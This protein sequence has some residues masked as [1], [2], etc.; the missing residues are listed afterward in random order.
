MHTSFSV[1]S[2]EMKESAEEFRRLHDICKEMAALIETNQNYANMKQL[3]LAMKK[4]GFDFSSEYIEGRDF[5]FS[6]QYETAFFT[7]TL[8]NTAFEF[9]AT[10]AW[11]SKLLSGILSANYFCSA[12]NSTWADHLQEGKM[13]G[14]DA[15]FLR[16][17]CERSQVGST[18]L[19]PI[20]VCAR[21]VLGAMNYLHQWYGPRATQ[22]LK[23]SQGCT[24]DSLCHQARRCIYVSIVISVAFLD[25][26][27]ALVPFKLRRMHV[28][29][30]GWK[31]A[32]AVANT[33]M[34]Y[35]AWLDPIKAEKE[36]YSSAF[37]DAFDPSHVESRA[38][39]DNATPLIEKTHQVLHASK[40]QSDS[41]NNVR[42]GQA[43]QVAKALT[44]IGLQRNLN[45][46]DKAR[47]LAKEALAIREQAQI[48]K[49]VSS[50]PTAG[51]NLE[52]NDAQALA[53]EVEVVEKRAAE[54]KAQALDARAHLVGHLRRIKEQQ[55]HVEKRQQGPAK[56]EEWMKQSMRALEEASL[57]KEHARALLMAKHGI[58]HQ[59]IR[60][61]EGMLDDLL[62]VEP[63]T[64]HWNLNRVAKQ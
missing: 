4:E 32:I 30:P 42:A 52:N 22:N 5:F 55:Q 43:L 24:S 8:T 25:Y 19:Q 51:P 34:Q 46:R 28:Q 37:N 33:N 38:P 45:A 16:Y 50:E 31:H 49:T 57:A 7:E 18:R 29:H 63:T 62:A 9:H 20:E 15:Q 47:R 61:D 6:S 60:M 44:V 39:P 41:G 3:L 48:E 1:N 10:Y 21:L 36:Q 59:Q 13:L 56:F 12:D 27:Y 35:N 17:T 58:T 11:I 14:C 23:Q 2:E 40:I 54:A 26:A 64:G 53:N